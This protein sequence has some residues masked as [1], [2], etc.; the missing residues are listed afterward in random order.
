[1][2][3]LFSCF[4]VLFI[5]SPHFHFLC[6]YSLC[7]FLV[8]DPFL[9]VPKICLLDW[10]LP[11]PPTS[12]ISSCSCGWLP[13]HFFVASFLSLGLFV[14]YAFSSTLLL[15]SIRTRLLSLG[16]MRFAPW[17]SG[18]ASGLAAFNSTQFFS[19]LND[20]LHHTGK[21]S[22]P[23]S[24]IFSRL[25]WHPHFL[26]RSSIVAVFYLLLPPFFQPPPYVAPFVCWL[27]IRGNDAHW[28]LVTLLSSMFVL[29]S[30]L[31]PLCNSKNKKTLQCPLPLCRFS[32]G[33]SHMRYGLH[34]ALTIL[35]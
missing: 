7:L 17:L 6:P 20:S 2:T 14:Y 32:Y 28:S 30:L 24:N 34:V 19:L 15:Y 25:N 1:M 26:L 3:C 35:I 10:M 31:Q 9:F 21:S 29:S 13:Y 4:E 16:S 12:F 22:P 5:M 33:Q 11:N 18:R 8:C 27:L 23:H